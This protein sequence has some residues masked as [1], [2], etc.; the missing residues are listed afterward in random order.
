MKNCSQDKYNKLELYLRSLQGCQVEKS[1]YLS[2]MA[3]W[4]MKSV[5]SDFSDGLARQ[6]DKLQI[7][8]L[9]VTNNGNAQLHSTIKRT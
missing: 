5:P 2:G 4:I 6:A 3:M 8:D 9:K 7:K 1:F